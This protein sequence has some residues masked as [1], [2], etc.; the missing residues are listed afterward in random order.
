MNFS[1]NFSRPLAYES[2]VLAL[3]SARETWA[4]FPL[5]WLPVCLTFKVIFNRSRV[6]VVLSFSGTCPPPTSTLYI[7][8]FCIMTPCGLVD[9]T[10]QKTIIFSLA[11]YVTICRFIASDKIIMFLI[12]GVIP[13]KIVTVYGAS[14]Q[15]ND[16]CRWRRCSV[17][18][19]KE[20][21]L[22]SN[23]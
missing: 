21:L 23:Q 15:W 12:T 18:P 17:S 22:S 11:L 13:V 5:W 14:M 7:V 2:Y 10:S 9:V 6:E 20:W 3:S 4:V 8:F 1:W 16:S 19:M